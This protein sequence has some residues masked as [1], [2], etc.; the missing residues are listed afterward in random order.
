MH[1]DSIHELLQNLI[2]K[3]FDNYQSPFMKILIVPQF[4]TCF[5]NLSLF[6]ISQ[7]QYFLFLSL[8]SFFFLSPHDSPSPNITVSTHMRNILDFITDF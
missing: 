5:Y 2:H 8:F 7:K 1:Y 3:K 4:E 6:D